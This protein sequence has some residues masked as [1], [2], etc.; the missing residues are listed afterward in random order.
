MK[1]SFKLTHK[2]GQVPL[3]TSGVASP[4]PVKISDDTISG[5]PATSEILRTRS[6]GR[7][8]VT[9]LRSTRTIRK[10]SPNQQQIGVTT[11][12]TIEVPEEYFFRVKM[13]AL[14]RRIKEK[15]MW[16]EIL[17]EYFASHPEDS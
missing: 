6:Q 4:S 7:S 14:K 2:P 9:D 1:K 13:H 11:R 15:D 8:V 3:Q 12:K 16:A 17:E 10:E 5:E